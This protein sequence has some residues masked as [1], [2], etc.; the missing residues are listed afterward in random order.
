MFKS[1]TMLAGGALG[2]SVAV[3]TGAPSP[4][5]LLTQVT[6]KSVSINSPAGTASSSCPAGWGTQAKTSA[7]PDGPSTAKVAGVRAGQHACYDRLV[8][9]LGKGTRPGY[10]ARY[11]QALR[12]QGSGS[13]IPLR[14]SAKLEITV[15]ANAR[16]RFP[17]SARELA[18]VAGFSAFRQLAGAGSF[19]GQ[20]DMGIGLRTRL[21]FRV[22]VINGPGSDS[23]LVVDVARHR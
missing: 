2:V 7:R 11:V 18:N 13:V 22:F 16:S 23:R 9:D 10:H 15:N 19:E 1:M 17:A 12:S 14:G 21:P 8:I 4:Q 6:G 3:A 20:T 5:A